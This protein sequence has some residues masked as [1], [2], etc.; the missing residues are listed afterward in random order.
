VKNLRIARVLYPKR[1]AAPRVVTE[2]RALLN[3]QRYAERA[4]MVGRQV[5]AET[6]AESAAAAILQS[7]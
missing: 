1:Y 7:L 4:D 3:E 6:G 2:L 5:R